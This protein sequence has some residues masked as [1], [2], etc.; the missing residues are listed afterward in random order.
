M[1]EQITIKLNKDK[2]QPILDKVNECG[3]NTIK[4]P[5]ELAGKAIFYMYLLGCEELPELDNKTRLEFICNKLGISI[6]EGFL[7]FISKYNDFIT[8]GKIPKGCRNLK[9]K[10]DTTNL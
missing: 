7:K 4:T 2:F 9:G 8:E 10:V 3:G 6:E 1:T 5:S